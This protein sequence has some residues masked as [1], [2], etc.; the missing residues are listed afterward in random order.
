MKPF[1]SHSRRR[2]R[3]FGAHA[4]K[5]NAMSDGRE[6]A[7]DAGNILVAQ[8][9]EN[10]GGAFI[11]EF[12]APGFG[13]DLRAGGIM[14][15]VDDGAFVPALKTRGP[16]D[17]RET[18]ARSRFRRLQFRRSARRRWRA[19]RFASDARQRDRA[20]WPYTDSVTNSKRRFAFRGARADHFFRRRL[21]F[22]RDDRNVRLDDAGLFAGD[23]FQRVPEPFLMIVADRRD[24]GDDRRE[25]V[26]RIEPAAE[27]G[28]EHNQFAIALLEMIE[29]QRGRDFKKCRMRIPVA[30]RC[31]D[32]RRDLPR[33]RLSRSSRHS[34]GCARDR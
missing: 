14:R 29:R 8:H 34:P 15:A 17:V 19:R 10:D 30:D 25:R 26:R 12:C 33:P 9:G 21:L 1:A 2:E 5:N 11:A 6:G 20:G 31:A 24:H 7:P 27:A 18:L 23:L 32:R 16:L 4:G 22:R 3:A 13:Q 28:L